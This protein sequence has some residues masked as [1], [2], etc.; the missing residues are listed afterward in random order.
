MADRLFDAPGL[1]TLAEC[2]TCGTYA[3]RP[4]PSVEELGAFYRTYFT[5]GD[6]ATGLPSDPGVNALTAAALAH[7]GYPRVATWPLRLLAR[8][9]PLR[10][11]L[12]GQAYWLPAPP[13]RLI[14]IG[15]GDGRH[16]RLLRT[17]GWDVMGIDTDPAAAEVA[18]T[19]FGLDVRTC[20]LADV[21]RS[22]FDA[23][24]LHHVIEHVHDLEGTLDHVRRILRPEGRCVLV[25]PNASSLARHIFGRSWI[26]WDPPRHLQIFSSGALTALLERHGFR[27]I[28]SRTTARNARFAWSASA[29]IRWSAQERTGTG[30]PTAAGRLG[31]IAFQ[32][33]ETLVLAIRKDI[34]EELIVVGKV[35]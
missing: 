21:P 34:G 32:A 8:I 7:V 2:E 31:G 23:A 11:A 4:R 35:S 13:G 12:L 17:L 25:T 19:R 3:L 15:C 10:D 30:S 26:H 29:A 14:D 27:D 22:S 6:L 1:R 33:L 9:P 28:S 16:L 20:A 18:R 24:V 5:H